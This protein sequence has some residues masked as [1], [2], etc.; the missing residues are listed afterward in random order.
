[1]KF[2]IYTS[3]IFLITVIATVLRSVCVL[4]EYEAET[5]YFRESA[6][7]G[8][9]NAAFAAGAICCLAAA[10]LFPRIAPLS[11][12]SIGSFR[13][14]AWKILYLLAAICCFFG[15]IFF[16]TNRT[17]NSI[18][19]YISTGILS[20]LLAMFFLL[21]CTPDKTKSA[22]RTNTLAPWFCVAGIVLLFLLL[23]SSYFDLSVA[24]NGPFTPVFIFSALS[25]CHFFLA[26]M[27]IRIGRGAPRI[28]FALTLVAFFLCS[29][30]GISGLLFSQFG[31]V[32]S[33]VTLAESARPVLLLAVAFAALAR[34]LCFTTAEP[35]T[36][37]GKNQKRVEA[38]GENNS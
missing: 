6:L 11:Q 13:E 14:T 3:F 21:N 38:D 2:K 36:L 9:S 17:S 26:E 12:A 24:Q 37:G 32:A 28:Q 19:M 29:S 20:M 35:V 18:I 8:I 30:V 5:G 15:G 34:L 7:A 1:M 22:A 16:L 25:G 4:T 10:F 27:G 23:M 33:A 31:D